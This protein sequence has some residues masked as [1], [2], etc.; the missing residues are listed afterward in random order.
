MSRIVPGRGVRGVQFYIGSGASA[1]RGISAWRA[2]TAVLAALA[3]AG[4]G[5]ALPLTGGGDDD[6]P[7]GSIGEAGKAQV[8]PVFKDLTEED[9]RR[10]RS[11][12]GVALDP[13]GNGASATWDNPESGLRGTFSPVGGPFVKNDQVCRAFLASAVMKSGQQWVQGS[14]CRTSGDDWLVRD[15]RP[16]KKPA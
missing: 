4:C 3:L 6:M 13:Q 15:V 2:G 5:L 12:L 14:A 10:A 16:W 1:A 8:S 7:T 9:W 11:A